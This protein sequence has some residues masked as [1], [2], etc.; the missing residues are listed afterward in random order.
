[1][2]ASWNT[3][4]VRLR[5]VQSTSAT[6]MALAAFAAIPAAANAQEAPVEDVAAE[7][8][9]VVTGFRAALESAVAE[10]KNA[11]QVVESVSAEDIGKLPD[12]SIA[13]SIARLPGL[14]SQRL[15]GRSAFISIRGFGPD[16]SQTLLNGREQT[17]TGDN[18]A[19]EFDQYPSEMVSQVNVY[20]TPSANIIGQ[21]LVGTVDI[22]TARPLEVGKRVLAVGVKGSITDLGKLNAGS[23]DKGYRVNA[24]YIDTFGGDTVGVALTASYVDESYQVQEYNAWGYNDFAGSRLIGGNKSFVT[25]TNLKRLGLGGTLQGDLSDNVR[26]TAD[27]F[28]S[29]F[30]DDI[31]KRGIELPL[32]S[33]FGWTSAGINPG[34]TVQDGHIVNGTFTDIEAVVNNHKVVRSAD[35]LSTGLNV[36]WDIGNGW[37]ATFDWGTSRTDRNELVFESNAGTGRGQGVGAR[38]TIGFTQSTS[39]TTFSPTLNYADP[40]LIRLTSPMGWGG[41]AGGQDGYYNDRVVED[42]LSTLRFDLEKEL[43]GF[44]SAI[45]AGIGYTDRS[46]SLVPDESFVVLAS[47][48][49]DLRI[50]DQYLLRPTN[51]SY[52]G[53][54]QVIS[55]NPQ[56]LLDA[57]IYRLVPNAV[58]DV[59]TKAYVVDEQLLTG[60]LQAAIDTEVGSS[61]LTGNVGVQIIRTD[62]SSSGAVYFGNTPTPLTNGTKYTDVLPSLNLALRTPSDFVFRVGLSR[63]IQR[64]RMD[65]M[66][67]AI[68]YGV[69]RDGPVPIIR[70]SG[71]NPFLEPMRANALD[72]TV[73]KYF[74][75]KGYISAQLY[76]K[77]LLNWIYKVDVPFDFTGF[78]L[79]SEVVPSRN[80]F[81]N[82]PINGDGG[83]LYGIEL[84]G[85]LPFETFTA[86][87][88]GF[89]VTGGVAY[90][91]SRLRPAP[92]VN[93]G[94]IDG[95]S[96]WVANGT[97]YFERSGFSARGSV[98][99]RSTFQGELAG[100]GGNRTRRRARGETLVDA[101][102]GYEFQDG[103]SLEGLS[104]F[105]QGQ[106]LTNEPF[107]TINPG[108][109][110]EVIDYQTYGRRYQAG[111]TFKF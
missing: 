3:N 76:Y 75:N 54:G 50:P 31:I 71:G 109:P 110:L 23:D 69:N 72:L 14:T 101:Q 53:L 102:L 57:G 37:N 83:K 99:Y 80:G 7:E 25:S 32:S 40:N 66:R 90:T 4:E 106:N 48:A 2:S 111:I 95:Y 91:K 79:G 8:V 52:L 44:F 107:S 60:Y 27:I 24:T 38:D 49:A 81:V 108:E 94:D 26:L 35:L 10:K 28:Y 9:I 47:G 34:Y 92:G 104:L 89:G 105:I 22:R 85:T 17:S 64:P 86:A 78:P 103:S 42:E 65:D 21:G 46:K 93:F 82:L 63:Q 67:V 87:L 29:K 58:A 73:E 5:L 45:R 6:A 77:K 70:G 98:R 56:E 12:A 96:R 41:I 62:Q 61:N 15:N 84:A 33:A 43:D 18:R 88:E 19:V 36:D 51:L 20:K 30:D 59:G 11:E 74:G 1:M 16:L 55:Y 100:F 39:G 68:G 13:E 97:A